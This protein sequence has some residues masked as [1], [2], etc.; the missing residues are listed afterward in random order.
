MSAHLMQRISLTQ[1]V[2]KINEKA[3]IPKM[4]KPS[5]HSALRPKRHSV[6][7]IRQLLNAANLGH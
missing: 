7:Y 3:Y 4:A 2:A 6:H 1:F 5:K